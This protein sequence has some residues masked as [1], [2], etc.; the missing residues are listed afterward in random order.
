MAFLHGEP[1]IQYNA[2]IG[3]LPVTGEPMEADLVT[4]ALIGL[5]V[6]AVVNPLVGIGAFATWVAA[7]PKKKKSAKAG[8]Y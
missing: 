5:A 3:P 6:A 4:S 8:G 7:G 1:T 2:P